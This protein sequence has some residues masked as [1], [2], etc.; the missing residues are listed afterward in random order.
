[1]LRYR[2]GGKKAL[3]HPIAPCIPRT[4]ELLIKTRPHGNQLC[5]NLTKLHSIK[6]SLAPKTSPPGIQGD[7]LSYKP[8]PRVFPF[9]SFHVDNFHWG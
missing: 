3:H 9:A 6:R 4:R 1:M 5:T 8:S 2:R 7:G